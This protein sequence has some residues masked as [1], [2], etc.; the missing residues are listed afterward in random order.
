MKEIKHPEYTGKY[1]VGDM[2][3]N[4]YIHRHWTNGEY[5][6]TIIWA[7]RLITKVGVS[8]EG[9]KDRLYS[10]FEITENVFKEQKI[11]L[12]PKDIEKLEIKSNF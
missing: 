7:N 2:K 6:M 10:N 5:T 4:W 12:N 1:K 11:E 3:G 9:T 8:G